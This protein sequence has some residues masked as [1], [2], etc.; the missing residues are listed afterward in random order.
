MSSPAKQED[1]RSR[2]ID[3]DDPRVLRTRTRLTAAYRALVEESGGGWPTVMAVSRRAG[4]PRS[5]FYAHFRS[6]DAL[7]LAALAESTEA[8]TA[9][10]RTLIQAGGERRTVNTEAILDLVRHFAEQ[11]GV[12]ERLEDPGS[13][14]ART[15]EDIL[16]AD[17][18]RALHSRPSLQADAEVTARFAAA[19]L[20]RVISWWLRDGDGLTAEDLVRELIT[21]LPYDLAG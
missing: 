9:R 18:L 3:N 16:V 2:R 17:V 10:A 14:F 1:L 15:I 21:I 11:P 6:V 12:R 19:G 4:V 13:E 20:M 5:S 8:R 7:A